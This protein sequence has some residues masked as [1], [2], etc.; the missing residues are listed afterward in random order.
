LSEDE[1]LKKSNQIISKEMKRRGGFMIL[2]V[3]LKKSTLK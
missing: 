2:M 1:M 3:A